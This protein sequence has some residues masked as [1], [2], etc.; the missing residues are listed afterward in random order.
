MLDIVEFDHIALF[1]E[2]R[3]RRLSGGAPT[4]FDHAPGFS[5]T[6]HLFV[7]FWG[8]RKGKIMC[9]TIKFDL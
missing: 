2:T 4:K 9:N 8:L 5:E 7:A 3:Q 1:R 6:E